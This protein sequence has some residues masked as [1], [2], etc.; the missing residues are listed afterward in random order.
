MSEN[1]PEDKFYQEIHSLDA[2]IPSKEVIKNYSTDRKA[3]VAIALKNS[4]RKVIEIS[5]MMGISRPYVYKLLKHSTIAEAVSMEDRTYLENFLEKKALL[6]SRIDQ[7]SKAILQELPKYRDVVDEDTGNVYREI[8]RGSV[9]AY[10]SL[11]RLRFHYEKEMLSLEQKANVLPSKDVGA[12]ATLAQS[13]PE[14]LAKE[15][16]ENLTDTELLMKL[17]ADLKRN[18]KSGSLASLKD[19]KILGD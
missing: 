4:G 11:S 7:L 12:Y 10:E 16:V 6:Q 17:V 8:E 5:E 9:Q 13:K 18:G 19:E 1:T 2:E 3:E 14:E 15:D